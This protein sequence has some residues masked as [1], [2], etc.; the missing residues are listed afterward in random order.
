ARRQ[1]ASLR[2][3]GPLRTSG[4]PSVARVMKWRSSGATALT[5]TR[6][7]RGRSFHHQSTSSDRN[8]PILSLTLLSSQFGPANVPS[9]W[10]WAEIQACG[11]PVAPADC[12]PVHRR[13]NVGSYGRVPDDGV[14]A[15]S[16]DEGV[17]HRVILASLD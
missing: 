1:P 15:G 16:A 11:Q 10:K 17:G 12:S 4:Q 14:T 13:W 5:F 3:G 8:P 7:S 6:T 2:R 9:S